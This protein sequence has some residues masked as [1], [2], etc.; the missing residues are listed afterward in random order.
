MQAE[1]SERLSILSMLQK[2]MSER[3]LR[4]TL[5]RQQRLWD[6]LL[7]HALTPMMPKSIGQLQARHA[8]LKSVAKQSRSFAQNYA[9]TGQALL[10]AIEQLAL[11]ITY[12]ADTDNGAILEVFLGFNLWA[13]G[14]KMTITL[15]DE[16]AEMTTVQGV[17][18]FYGQ[19]LAWGRGHRT[20][21]RLFGA[22]QEFSQSEQ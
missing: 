19:L 7:L 3:K 16:G 11:P 15:L 1:N 20:L 13:F 12:A 14:G 5:P 21:H 22:I 4:L 8:L 18:Q 10:L 2:L 17:T 6:E 9:L